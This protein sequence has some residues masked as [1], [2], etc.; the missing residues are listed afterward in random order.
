MGRPST[1][2][3]CVGSIGVPR[4]ECGSWRHSSGEHPPASDITGA[5]RESPGRETAEPLGFFVALPSCSFCPFVSL[6]TETLSAPPTGLFVTNHGRVHYPPGSFMLPQRK[7]SIAGCPGVMQ[8]WAG[9][10]AL[11][12]WRQRLAWP[13][14]GWQLC[15][16]LVLTAR[17]CRFLSSGYSGHTITQGQVPGSTEAGDTLLI[18]TRHLMSQAGARE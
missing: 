6:S 8:G 14:G 9:E 12:G 5:A 3:P 15:L 10:A 7:A 16:E 17:V 13:E 2:E 4:L 18:V 11:A 1:S